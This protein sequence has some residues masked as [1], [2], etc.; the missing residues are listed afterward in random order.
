[1]ARRNTLRRFQ[2][3][4]NADTTTS[5]TGPFTDVSGLDF[6]TYLIIVDPTVNCEMAVYFKNDEF[7]QTGQTS[8]KLDF[9]EQIILDGSLDTEYTLKIENHGFKWLSIQFENDLGG[10]GNLNAWVSGT[11]VGA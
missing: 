1:M 9:G 4:D 6:I 8:Y 10:T 3:F 11:T 5:P 7:N 2:V